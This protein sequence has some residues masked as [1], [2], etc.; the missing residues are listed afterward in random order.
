MEGFVGVVSTWI[1]EALRN[2]QF[3]SLVELNE[4]IHEKLETSNH[5]PFQK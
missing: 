4:T 3:L 2:R 5:K 1:L